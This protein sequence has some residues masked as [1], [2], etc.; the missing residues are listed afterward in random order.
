[1]SETVESSTGRGSEN[2][3]PQSVTPSSSRATVPILERALILESES[4]SSSMNTNGPP[5]STGCPIVP[6]AS[7]PTEAPG[8]LPMW[9][10]VSS[11]I[12]DSFSQTFEAAGAAFD[13]GCERYT[14]IRKA[15]Q[16]SSIPGSRP[17]AGQRVARQVD[18]DAVCE[19]L[20]SNRSN[21]FKPPVPLGQMVNILVELWEDEGLYD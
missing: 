14:A 11:G 3:C 1:M 20:A 13:T 16:T 18:V 10:T 8:P 2:D 19:C 17:P 9:L 4:P 21:A 15:W 12:P 7:E 6:V 5:M